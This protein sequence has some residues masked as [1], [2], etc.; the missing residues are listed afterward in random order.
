M[1]HIDMWVCEYIEIY[2]KPPET[3]AY[4][5][6]LHRGP[7]SYF[8]ER[9]VFYLDTNTRHIQMYMYIIYIN[10]ENKFIHYII[11]S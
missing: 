9:Q 4:D 3:H 11:L 1:F 8:I 10:K 6:A 2:L 7:P 5:L